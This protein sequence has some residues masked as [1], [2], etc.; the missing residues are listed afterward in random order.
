MERF[1]RVQAGVLHVAFRGNSRDTVFYDDEDYIVLLK[2]LQK[3]LEKNASSL[4]EFCIMTNHCHL[5]VRTENITK[6]MSTFLR[7]YSLWHNKKH[8]RSNKLFSTP[9]LSSPQYTERDIL[10]MSSY[11][12]NNPVVAGIC[13]DFRSYRWSSA[14]LH[15]N[16]KD[17][18]RTK[19]LEYVKMDTSLIDNQFA[20]KEE[21]LKFIKFMPESVRKKIEDEKKN[22]NLTPV[23]E[24]IELAN[25]YITSHF[26]NSASIS[27]L[28]LSESDE[29]IKY[30]FHNARC[31]YAQLAGLFHDSKERIRRL[32]FHRL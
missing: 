17:I 22:W 5:L 30:L 18:I 8:H 20:N 32:M 10:E 28:T 11:I 21:F 16:N 27:D 31:T 2:Y 1:K 19:L 12:L 23:R 24:L 4:L 13:E 14:N 7:T 26:H 15:F 3:A 25:S 9:F 29:L 6:L